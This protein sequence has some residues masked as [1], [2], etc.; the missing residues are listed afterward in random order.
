MKA[1]VEAPQDAGKEEEQL[2]LQTEWEEPQWQ[3][4]QQQQGERL[5]E[6]QPGVE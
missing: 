5:L 4:Q 1:V 6:R 3:P 2:E